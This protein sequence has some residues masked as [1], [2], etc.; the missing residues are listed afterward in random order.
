VD[1]W[2]VGVVLPELLQFGIQNLYDPQLDEWLR[3]DSFS[4]EP[5]T[6]RPPARC[7]T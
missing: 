4:R 6:V 3:M 5:G 7:R 2:R 1:H